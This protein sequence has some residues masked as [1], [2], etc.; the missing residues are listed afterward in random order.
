M[1]KI[2]LAGPM[3][4]HTKEG[5]DW[6]RREFIKGLPAN[7]RT[8]SPFRNKPYLNEGFIDAVVQNQ[9]CSLSTPQG[10]NGRDSFDVRS[11]DMVVACFLGTEMP[12]IGTSAEIWGAWLLNKPVVMIADPN[13]VHA[14]H[15]MLSQACTNI[16]D[17]VEEA[18]AVVSS[19]FDYERGCK[20]WI[21]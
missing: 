4:N 8:A 17:S 7:I 11:S 15:P 3:T 10:I 14:K 2:Y 16:V 20:P 21:P 12:S 9:E 18:V 19:F 13:N 1:P 5:V 6:W